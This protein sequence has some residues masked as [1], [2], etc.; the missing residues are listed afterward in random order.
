MGAPARGCLS[1]KTALY[2]RA[3]AEAIRA[4]L[5]DLLDGLERVLAERLSQDGTADLPAVPPAEAARLRVTLTRGHV[6][7]ESVYRDP[8]RLRAAAQSL[9]DLIVPVG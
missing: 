8:S 3:G 1:A 7:I 9:V 6:V 2:T 4:G 5:R